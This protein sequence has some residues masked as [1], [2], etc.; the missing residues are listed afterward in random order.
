MSKPSI[1]SR[2]YEKIM[3][4][5][6]RRNIISIIIIILLIG[7][8]LIYFKCDNKFGDIKILNR[9]TSV[10]KIFKTEKLYLTSNK[11]I[12]DRSNNKNNDLKNNK[13]NDLKNNKNNDLKNNENN[14]LKNSDDKENKNTEEI[15][16]D[17]EDS[18]QNINTVK[19]SLTDGQNIEASFYIVDGKRYFSKIDSNNDISFDFSPS[20]KG[21]VL[22]SLKNQDMFYATADGSLIEITKEKYVSSSKKEYPKYEEL[23]KNP[24]YI[25][26]KD[27]K[28]IDEYNIAYVSE[29]PWIDDRHINY[30]W[31]YNL[32]S[33]KHRY[34]SNTKLQG[35]KIIL[36][37]LHGD[38]LNLLVDGK[39]FEID[40]EGIIK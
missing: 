31:V 8:V 23:K 10:T 26:H 30:L 16:N 40:S 18:P 13:N 5:R 2:D 3:K 28:F 20:R 27:P 33:K 34:I 24:K 19:F 36:K 35:H 38:F 39:S 25:W 7:I 4:R 14:D 1:F 32:K 11:K 22:C 15:N 6:R 17:E 37:E 29:L 12:N 9:L 21:L